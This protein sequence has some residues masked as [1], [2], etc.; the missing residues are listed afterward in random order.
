MRVWTAGHPPAVQWAA[1]SGRWS[2]HDTEGPLLGLIDDADFIGTRAIMR[3]GDVIMLYTDGMVETPRRDISVGIDALVAAAER[4][5]RGN[6]EQGA[7]RLVDSL[8]SRDDDR[9]LLLL[10]RR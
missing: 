2:V 3:S 5:L 6:F 1:G 7:E 4:D 9:A 8:G 10:H